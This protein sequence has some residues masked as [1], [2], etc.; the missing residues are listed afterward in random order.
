MKFK[1]SRRTIRY[2]TADLW[3][4]SAIAQT[5]WPHIRG[6]E[7]A[8]YRVKGEAGDRTSRNYLVVTL[9]RLRVIP[10]HPKHLIRPDPYA[11]PAAGR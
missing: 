1:L 5:A 11:P 10:F 2:R 3:S 7:C 4:Q 8:Q 9:D 6:Q